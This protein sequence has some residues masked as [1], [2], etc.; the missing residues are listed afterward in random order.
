MTEDIKNIFYTNREIV[1][2]I[3][4]VIRYLRRENF[5]SAMNES[6]ELIRLISESLNKIIENVE[7]FNSRS[8]VMETEGILGMLNEILN[9]QENKDYVLFADLLELRLRMFITGM[10][11]IIIS[12]E[13]LEPEAGIY[14]KNLQVLKE[15]NYDLYREIR[16]FSGSP[17]SNEQTGLEYSLEYTSSGLFTI[18]CSKI[19]SNGDNSKR[20]YL[21]SN[22]NPMEEAVILCEQWYDRDIWEYGIYG[23]GLGY[24]LKAMAEK[25]A[26]VKISVFESDIRIIK[27]FLMT[28]EADYL[29]R[30][31]R[32]NIYYDADLK[33]LNEWISKKDI[34]KKLV[35]HYPSLVLI[36]SE[37]VHEWLEDYFIQYSSIKGQADKLN[38]NF[39]SNIL[40]YDEPVDCLHKEFKGKTLYI[41]AAGPS[42]DGNIEKLRDIKKGIILAVGTVF[43]KLLNSGIRPDYVIITDGNI[44]VM[45][46]IENISCKDIPM[47]IMS[48]AYYG[49]AEN[50]KGKKYIICQK[51]Y[52]R[53]ER[54]SEE[55]GYRLYDT[56]GSV[57]TTAFDIGIRFQCKKII[58]AGLD[59]AYT[60]NKDHSSDTAEQRTVNESNLKVVKDI[61]GND[62]YTSNNLNIYRKWIEERVKKEDC[63]N[64]EI[65]DATEGG[66]AVAGLNIKT[67]ES[68]IE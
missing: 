60:N 6:S 18:S 4:A 67:L 9:A 47:L 24:H 26:T 29:L 38:S 66:A 58:F 36:K 32:L 33:K 54:F 52:D 13:I 30:Q 2:R 28:N 10:Q 55:K 64:I 56:G 41:V 63:R 1:C 17:L 68:C 46:Q 14:E 42:L 23:L 21:H 43:K 45:K 65:V 31:N 48:S 12:N 51:G 19:N 35:I 27:L 20:I 44:N 53:S 59:L 3:D 40:N 7:Y 15:N 11:E 16:D 61:Y 49:V 25:D 8:F 57:I 5:Y 62:I 50:Y 37:R 22:N 34:Y 39:R